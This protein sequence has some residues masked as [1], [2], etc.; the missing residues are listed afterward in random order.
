MIQ[1]LGYT[2]D[3]GV[4]KSIKSGASPLEIND[5]KRTPLCCDPVSQSALR[6]SGKVLNVA[7]VTT[8]KVEK[9]LSVAYRN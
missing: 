4:V 7:G 2:F 8:P 6:T 3:A 1:T 9:N 5:I